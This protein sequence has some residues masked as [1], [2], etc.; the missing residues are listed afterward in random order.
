MINKINDRKGVKRSTC[1]VTVINISGPPAIGKTTFVRQLS[2]AM[3]RHDIKTFYVQLTGFHYLSF[4]F[5]KFLY[6]F[7]KSFG[8]LSFFYR[9]SKVATKVNPY[10]CIPQEYLKPLLKFTYFLELISINYKI[11]N[12]LLK[13]M[14]LKP[15][16]VLIDEGFPHIMLNYIMF[17]HARR[18]S[19]YTSL[20]RYLIRFLIKLSKYFSIKI[21]FIFPTDM[22]SITRNWKN[23][24][25]NLPYSIIS[26]HLQTYITIIQY[27]IKLLEDASIEVLILNDFKMD[28]AI[29]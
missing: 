1:A 9:D 15:K 8:K 6:I 12:L 21:V 5:S 18:C 20:I 22:S 11:L 7:F 13:I 3:S 19:L 26:R 25:P 28:F 29:L 4:V 16:I 14:I 17:Y 24:D 2:I 10:D 23:R 27:I